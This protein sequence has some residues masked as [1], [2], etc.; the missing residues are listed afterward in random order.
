MIKKNKS[1]AQKKK[2]ARSHRPTRIQLQEAAEKKT[3][4]AANVA[5]MLSLMSTLA[6]EVIGLTCRW[7]TTLVEPIELLTVLSGVMLFVALIAGILTLI[8]IPIVLRL[9]KTRPPSAIVQI[10]LFA[11]ALP[12]L[13]IGLQYFF[14]S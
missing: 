6:A 2:S 3:V 5:W 12:I 1:K 13:V 10:A 11:G 4:I 14:R 7:Y 8:L 9:G